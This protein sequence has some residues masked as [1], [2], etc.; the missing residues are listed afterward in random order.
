MTAG[1]LECLDIHFLSFKMHH[2]ITRN[3][4]TKHNLCKDLGNDDKYLLNLVQLLQNNLYLIKYLLNI[5]E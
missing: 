4:Q 5:T 1:K 2:N 3:I